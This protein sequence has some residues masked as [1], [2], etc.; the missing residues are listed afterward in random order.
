MEAA[1]ADDTLAWGTPSSSQSA[2]LGVVPAVTR[3]SRRYQVSALTAV[4]ARVTAA[5][6]N[7]IVSLLLLV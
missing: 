7:R 3:T 6:P 2:V 5:L 1:P 4:L